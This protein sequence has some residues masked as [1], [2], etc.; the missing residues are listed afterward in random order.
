MKQL[1]IM[2]LH[3]AGVNIKINFHP[4]EGTFFYNKLTNDISD[5]YKPFLTK[6]GKKVDYFIDFYQYH[7]REI[8][9]KRLGKSYKFFVDF[10]K[11]V[12]KR[13]VISYY[14]ISLI[15]FQFIVSN[16]LQKH[17]SENKGFILHASGNILHKQALLFSGRPGSG[18]STIMNLLKDIFEPLADDSII[19]KKTG[20]SFSCYQTPFIE[21]NDWEKKRTLPLQI[22]GIF[23]LRKA[24][25]Y[26][27]EEIKDTNYIMER[28]S[29]QMLIREKNISTQ[30]RHIL[31]FVRTNRFYFLYFGK[32]KKK[33]QKLFDDFS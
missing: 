23:F 2:Y 5:R 27:I 30:M 3:I 1:K 33:L 17:L 18:K 31:E 14:K 16:I 8:F 21:T 28:L 7:N 10:C 26:A 11:I 9:S 15:Q 12:G 29:K 19:I 4:T 6:T 13:R 22:G 32:N 25:R 20:T 24:R